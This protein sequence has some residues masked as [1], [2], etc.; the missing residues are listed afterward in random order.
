MLFEKRRREIAPGDAEALLEGLRERLGP[1]T[2]VCRSSGAEASVEVVWVAPDAVWR[3]ASSDFSNP[4]VFPSNGADPRYPLPTERR[5]AL[6]ELEIL[7]PGYRAGGPKAQALP[8]RLLVR[9]TDPAA[10]PRA[11]AGAGGGAVALRRVVVGVEAD[12]GP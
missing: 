9:W 8:R 3:L 12:A 6:R 10:E 2:R 1:E 4:G 7:T 11:S 5:E